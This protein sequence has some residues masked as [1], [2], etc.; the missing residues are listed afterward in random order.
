MHIHKDAYYLQNSSQERRLCSVQY[1]QQYL[2]ARMC[3]VADLIPR[4]RQAVPGALQNLMHVMIGVLGVLPYNGVYSLHL[5]VSLGV[6]NDP[7]WMCL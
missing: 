3:T 5:M 1:V 2:P 6:N 7:P 4:S